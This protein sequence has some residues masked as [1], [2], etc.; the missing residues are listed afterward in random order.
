[1]TSTSTDLATTMA[2]AVKSLSESYSDLK[3]LLDDP[4]FGEDPTDML[5]FQF[6]M[7]EWATKLS[8]FSNAI[9]AIFDAMKQIAQNLK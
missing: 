4:T 8:A 2:T 3:A 9:K 1:M 5:E 6:K 7:N